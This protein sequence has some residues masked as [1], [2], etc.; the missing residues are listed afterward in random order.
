MNEQISLAFS[1]QPTGTVSVSISVIPINED[2]NIASDRL[3]SA[4]I[5]SVSASEQEEAL[6]GAITTALSSF[7]S[8]RGI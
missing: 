8:V 4:N 1:V 7:R 2:G 3:L 5:S 6:I